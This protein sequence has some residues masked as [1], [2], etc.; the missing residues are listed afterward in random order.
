MRTNTAPIVTDDIGF[1]LAKATQRF[2]ELLMERFAARG[3]ADVRPSFGS[4][5]V[6]LFEQDGLRLGE[7]AAR[8]RLSKQAVTGLVKLCE[9]AGL[10]VRERDPDDGRAFRIR[11][12]VRGRELRSVAGS[13]LRGLDEELVASLGKANHA[14]LR[15]A[16]KGVIEL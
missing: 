14:A 3:F 5:L 4:I 11:L 13:E 15:R 6:P 9:D 7:L 2:N 1:L 8:G 10:V 16:L 12:S